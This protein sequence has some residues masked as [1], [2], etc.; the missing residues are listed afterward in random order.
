MRNQRT[1]KMATSESSSI[2]IITIWDG[3]WVEKLNE[4]VTL[5]L[6]GIYFDHHIE[7]FHIE[8]KTFLGQDLVKIIIDT[9]NGDFFLNTLK[10]GT[11]NQDLLLMRLEGW[12]VE[13]FGFLL[14]QR[15]P[16]QNKA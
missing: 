12:I 7:T 13:E 14:F 4:E 10:Q 2:E 6:K 16:D 9:D 5:S 3:S 11:L 8:G 1:G 15:V